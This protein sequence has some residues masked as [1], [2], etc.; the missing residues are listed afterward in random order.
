MKVYTKEII[1]KMLTDWNL[2]KK[3]F[4]LRSRQIWYQQIV[5]LRKSQINYLMNDEE[6]EEYAKCYNS[7]DYFAEKYC[8]IKLDGGAMGNIKLRDYQK[9]AIKNLNDNRFLIFLKSR[10]VGMTVSLTIYFLHEILFHKKNA[11]IIPFKGQVGKEF[12]TKFR[13]IYRLLPFFLQQGVICWSTKKVELEN[14]GKIYYDFNFDESNNIIL[15]NDFSRFPQQ[16]RIVSSIPE[17]IKDKSKK[18]IIDSGP[19]GFNLFYELVSNSE[20]PIDHPNKNVFFTQ[21]IYWFQVP[22]RDKNWKND[23]IKILGSSILFDQEYDL[24]FIATAT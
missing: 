23:I 16:E 6:L 18:L 24:K 1:E 22:G 21:R 5:G 8:N 9:E 4:T 14:G 13:D 2:G 15:L 3:G 11:L 12:I 10:Q 20:V 17:L 19:N 7:V